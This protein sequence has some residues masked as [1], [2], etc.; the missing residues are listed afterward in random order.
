MYELINPFHHHCDK[1]GS[2]F[3]IINNSLWEESNF[4][5][6]KKD[7]IRGNHYHKKTNELI[8]LIKGE[9]EVYLFDLNTKKELKL[10]LNE[11]S[12]LKINTYVLHTF[13]MKKESKW[14][15]LLSK[16]FDQKNP[17]I[18]YI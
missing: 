16:K 7:S 1:R 3:G 9:I 6:S 10:V 12:I 14:I 17:D 11:N 2:I 18:H 13:T 5:F 8:F 4:I 15:N